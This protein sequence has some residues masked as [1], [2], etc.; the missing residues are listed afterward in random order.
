[1]HIYNNE[2]CENISEFCL[3]GHTR[4][5]HCQAIRIF[6][7]HHFLQGTRYVPF[8]TVLSHEKCCRPTIGVQLNL[9]VDILL[10]ALNFLLIG[11]NNNVFYSSNMLPLAALTRLL[12]QRLIHY[13]SERLLPGYCLVFR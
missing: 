11:L 9:L 3:M 10:E 2:T 4:I 12:S 7:H 5:Q 13:V 8:T 1:V 6:L